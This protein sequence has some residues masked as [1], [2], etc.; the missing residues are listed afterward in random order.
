MELNHTIIWSSD[1]A[2]AV[3]FY[4]DILGLE[5]KELFGGH[6]VAVRINSALRLGRSDLVVEIQHQA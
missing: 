1:R 5:A 4:V 3:A 2:K 6:F